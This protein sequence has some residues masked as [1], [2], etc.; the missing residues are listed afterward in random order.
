[1]MIL[2]LKDF[3]QIASFDT[4]FIINR[5]RRALKFY[6]QLHDAYFSRPMPFC[7]K[8]PKMHYEG[9]RSTRFCG[10]R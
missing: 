9:W 8:G 5:H 4:L 2:R 6:H 1:M 10:A 7:A 3:D